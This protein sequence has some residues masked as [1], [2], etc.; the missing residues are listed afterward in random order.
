MIVFKN[1]IWFY[2]INIINSKFFL[3]SH[4]SIASNQIYLLTPKKLC[5]DIHADYSP[6]KSSLI[7]FPSSLVSYLK[8]NEEVKY[9]YAREHISN[10]RRDLKNTCR[11]SS[12]LEK[13][14]YGNQQY[15]LL[16]LQGK[17]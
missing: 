7:I 2:L 12:E 10:L 3:E 17:K 5:T 8:D 11:I 15:Y 14:L 9:D 13:V 16:S 4:K 1:F 6:K